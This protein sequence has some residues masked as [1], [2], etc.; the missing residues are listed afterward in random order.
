MK[1]HPLQGRT[2][3]QPQ[4]K[5]L[6]D[7]ELVI[8]IRDGEV[9]LLEVLMRRYN[10]RLFRIA[11]SVL[12]DDGE[13]EDVVQDTYIRAYRH[14]NEFKGPRGF[15][16]WLCRIASNR[17]LMRARRADWARRSR[18]QPGDGE[19]PNQETTMHTPVSAEPGPEDAAYRDQIRGLIEQ[20]IDALPEHYR[21]AF[22]MREVEQMSVR[23]TAACLGI[24]TA[25]VKS[26]VHRARRLLRRD[27][28][29]RVHAAARDAFGFDGKR[30]DR[31]VARVFEQLAS[32]SGEQR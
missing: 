31:L 24:E 12:G 6:T 1:L 8:R 9:A 5:Q 11:R 26:R 13:A 2:E 27:M 23:E 16:R 30:C 4:P 3:T 15:G 32:E 25:T 22:T 20:A 17:A 28:S 21:T 19:S 10:Q 18:P 29:R 14:L 7:N